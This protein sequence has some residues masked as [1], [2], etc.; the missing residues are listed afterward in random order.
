MVK[1]SCDLDTVEFTGSPGQVFK[2][3]EPDIRLR[4]T[5][6]EEDS[7]GLFS[8]AESAALQQVVR[9]ETRQRNL[10]AAIYKRKAAHV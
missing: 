1:E 2:I 8:Y 3:P 5:S 4:L 7:K 10:L 6:I 9:H